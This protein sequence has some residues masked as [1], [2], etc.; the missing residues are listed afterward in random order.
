MD[1]EYPVQAQEQRLEGSVVLQVWVGMDGSVQDLKLMK[2]YIVLGKAAV[3]AVRQWRFKP[4]G[5]N[6]K[7]IDYQTSVTVNFKLPG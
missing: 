4:Y 1:P 3:D 6:G 2:G 7:P 5:P